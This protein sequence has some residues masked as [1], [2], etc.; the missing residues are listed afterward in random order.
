MSNGK[1]NLNDFMRGRNGTDELAIASLV[2]A[3]VLLI[4]NC[5]AQQLWLTILVLAFIAYGLFRFLAPASAQLEEQNEH[6]VSLIGP[7]APWLRDPVAAWKESKDFKHLQCPHCGQMVRVPRGK[8]AI[9]VTCPR[10]HEKF[11]TRS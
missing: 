7:A 6:F 5:F 2:V 1:Q 9:R 3:L 4:I 10:C 11:E 8:G